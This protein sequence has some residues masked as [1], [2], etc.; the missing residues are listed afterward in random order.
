MNTIN[1][2]VEAGLLDITNL[3]LQRYIK[4]TIELEPDSRYRKDEIK[5]ICNDMK[6]KLYKIIQA[7]E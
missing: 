2:Q 4:N 7:L 5:K 6:R 1:L 3:K